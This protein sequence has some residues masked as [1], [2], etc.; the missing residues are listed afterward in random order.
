[1]NHRKKGIYILLILGSL[2]AGFYFG[3]ANF[4]EQPTAT[5]SEISLPDTEKQLRSGEEWLGKI[6]VIN[7]WATW[8]PPCREEIPMLITFQSQMSEANVQVLGIAHDL[9]D[10]ARLFSAQVGMNYPSLVAITGGNELLAAQGN[11]SHGALPYT[12]IF[13]KQ[14][15]QVD[16]KLGLLTYDELLALVKPYLALQ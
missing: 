15:V 16:S 5:L 13:N 6:V 10:S 7:H 11:S 14:G 8:C 3:Q 4:S 1:M 9:L 12:T 2:V